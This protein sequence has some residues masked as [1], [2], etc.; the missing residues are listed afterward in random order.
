MVDTGWCYVS[1]RLCSPTV[2]RLR[3]KSI[4][5]RHVNVA[6]MIARWP[7]RA[8]RV[9]PGRPLSSF[10]TWHISLRSGPNQCQNNWL[11]A[12]NHG[13]SVYL[14]LVRSHVAC[15]SHHFQS[16]FQTILG[17]QSLA[18]HV[19]Q[20]LTVAEFEWIAKRLAFHLSPN[21]FVPTECNDKCQSITSN[22]NSKYCRLYPP[23]IRTLL[24]ASSIQTQVATRFLRSE[25]LPWVIVCTCRG[26]CE[27]YWLTR[28]IDSLQGFCKALISRR[29]VN[30]NF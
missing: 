10:S 21:K 23:R 20:Q 8:D 6:R 26:A 13:V 18:T 17:Q 1:G 16:D 25:Y 30:L 7:R 19:P 27:T 14:C 28:L 24:K 22:W 5:W 3:K 2:A 12:G 15:Q 4:S 11:A 29:K 9:L